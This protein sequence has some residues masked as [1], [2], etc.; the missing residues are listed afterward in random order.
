MKFIHIIILYVFSM[1]IAFSQNIN[2]KAFENTDSNSVLDSI[3]N[4]NI[5]SIEKGVDIDEVVFS[6]KKKGEIMSRNSLNQMVTITSSGLKHAACCNLSESFI[7]SGTVDVNYS[8]AITGAKQIQLLG[9]AGVYT[10]IMTENIPNLRGAAAPF[11]LTYI[12]GSWMESIQVSKGATSVRNGYEPLTGLINV[13]YKKP[14]AEEVYHLNL[15]GDSELRNEFN[16]TASIELT[17]TLSTAFF[18]NVSRLD[19]PTDHNHD[20]FTDH[21]N[22]RMYNFMNRWEYATEKIE[23]RSGIQ[24]LD[25]SRFGGQKGFNPDINDQ[26]LYGFN[27]HTNRNQWYTKIGF[28]GYDRANT[29]A[30]LMLQASNHSQI[31]YFG[32]RKYSNM[33]N[34]IYANYLYTTYIHTLDHTIVA[35]TSF[36]V[37]D[38]AEKLETTKFNRIEFVPG[39]YSEYNYKF[40]EKLSFVAGMRADYH[41]KHGLFFT[42]RSF[43]RY[44]FSSHVVARLS[45]GKAFR[46]PFTLAENIYLLASSRNIIIEEELNMEEALNY[47]INI[48]QS[49]TMFNRSL[50]ISL[51]YYRTD[52]MNQV[53]VDIE[54]SREVSIYN[55][56]GQSYSNSFQAEVSYPLIR[57]LDVKLVYR[58]NDVQTD[59]AGQLKQKPY[60]SRDKALINLNYS[61][62]KGAWNFNYTLVY[63]GKG[64]IPST[65]LNPEE[66]QRG[67]LFS[68]YYMMNAQISK[69]IRR[70]EL[71]IGGENLTG[72]VQKNPIIASENPFS[73][74]FDATM[75]WGPVLGAKFYAGIRLTLIHEHEHEH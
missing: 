52:F 36:N 68:A 9:L 64:R 51:D 72:F 47:G 20:S 19:I 74:Y 27:V 31:S 17:D 10:Q 55:L 73:E 54:N 30:A 45:A 38:V 58:I 13:E 39:I 41:N 6:G 11:G 4:R 15:F 71:Y 75:V 62:P 50:T 66:F 23:V 60:N 29:S 37:D 8:D 43:L 53:L 67:E 65:A 70:W 25:E 57:N 33:H 42:P 44:E 63:N 34:H 32:N 2:G 1:E 46:S 35:G 49:H 12:P 56:R 26:N 5:I 18:V 22:F 59:Y 7:N 28:V 16:A 24:F 69:K 61:I 48:H 21:P 14:S 40:K 3:K